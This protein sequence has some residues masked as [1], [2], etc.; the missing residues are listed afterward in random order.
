MKKLRAT[1]FYKKLTPYLA[2]AY[3]EGFCEGEGRTEEE[4]LTAFQYLVD[5]GDCWNLQ[6]YYGRTA[7]ILM[8]EGL[9]LPAKKDHKDYYGNIIPA[10][11]L[12]K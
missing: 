10:N 8:K 3:A 12:P 2:C 5:T 9:I 1:K 4:V 6:G 11:M 7:T